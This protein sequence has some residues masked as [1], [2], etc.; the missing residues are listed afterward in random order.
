MPSR[1]DSMVAS[2]LRRPHVADP[3]R[4]RRRDPQRRGSC[5]RGALVGRRGQQGDHGVEDGG[6]GT[7][8]SAGTGGPP[9]KSP[10]RQPA[11]RGDQLAGGDV[12][13]VQPGL[14]VRVEATG[15]DVAQVERGRAEPADVADRADQPLDDAGLLAPRARPGSRTRW[16][17]GPA[18]GR[19]RSLQGSA[20]PSS[21]AP[22]APAGGEQLAEHGRVHGADEHPVGVGGGDRRRPQ[23][24]V[25]DEVGRAVDRVDVPR[26]R[27]TCRPG[28][29]PP[30][31]RWRRRAGRR[32]ARRRSSPRP[33]GRA[34]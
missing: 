19:S 18:P 3:L 11:S 8:S 2:R 28:P 29:C 14:V 17:R 23:R 34:R 16:R 6:G 13:A 1:S 7:R 27:P 5:G 12:P 20:R 31:R 24:E 33:P 9:A 26:R 30:R 32:S 4:R 22:A 21:V 15:G 10:L 25:V